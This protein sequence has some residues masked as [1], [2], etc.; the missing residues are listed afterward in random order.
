M[1]ETV[2]LGFTIAVERG[3]SSGRRKHRP[4]LTSQLS[5]LL[6]NEP[7]FRVRIITSQPRLRHDSLVCC[8]LNLAALS[9]DS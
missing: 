8:S 7:R 5:G 2:D 3:R 1:S 6:A 9:T 4:N